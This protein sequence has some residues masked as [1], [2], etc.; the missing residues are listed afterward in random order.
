MQRHFLAYGKRGGDINPILET[1]S[2][3]WRNG[4]EKHINDPVSI[5]NIQDASIH[6]NKSSYD[7]FV[8]SQN[9]T[10]SAKCM[11]FH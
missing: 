3:H 7:K 8:E 9:E 5:A 1:G 6:N 4:G 2:Y 11:S 10:V